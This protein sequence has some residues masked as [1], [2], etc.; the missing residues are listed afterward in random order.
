MVAHD[1][2]VIGGLGTQVGQV[3]AEEGIGVKFAN[4]GI[5]DHFE[6][7]AHAPYLYHKFG[8]DTEGLE[9]AMLGLME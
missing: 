3:L 1:H 2:N 5:P 9:K 4:L 8:F 7:M 6:P